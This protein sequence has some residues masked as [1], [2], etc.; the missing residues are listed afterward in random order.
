MQSAK[1]SNS[2]CERASC[3]AG[4]ANWQNFR[5]ATSG[6][7]SEGEGKGIASKWEQQALELIVG[8]QRANPLATI[9][10]GGGGGGD[11]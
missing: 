8:I 4:A 5:R 10:I 3:L 6:G 1:L 9:I 2:H 7:G 11:F